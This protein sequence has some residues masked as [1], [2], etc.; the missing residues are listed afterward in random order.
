[1]NFTTLNARSGFLLIIFLTLFIS[2]STVT[3]E[4]YFQIAVLNSN[5]FAGFAGSGQLRELESPSVKLGS[6]NE[7]TETMK[8]M[9]ILEFKTKAI[10]ESYGDL[11]KLKKTDDNKEMIEASKNLYEFIMPVYKSEYVKLAEM[12]DNNAP[13]EQIESFAAS[14]SSKYHPRFKELYDE[15]IKAGKQYAGKHSIKVNWGNL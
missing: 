3:P 9:E 7:S 14:I 2:C 6:D 10:E 11:K 8:R 5:L 4:K 12:Y 1:M 13:K 15:L